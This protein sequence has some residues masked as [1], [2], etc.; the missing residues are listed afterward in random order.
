[1]AS[2]STSTIFTTEAPLEISD[3]ERVV[4][5]MGFPYIHFMHTYFYA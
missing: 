3:C 5:D 1:M 2:S 4:Q